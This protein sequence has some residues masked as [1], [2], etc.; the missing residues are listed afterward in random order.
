MRTYSQRQASIPASTLVRMAITKLQSHLSLYIAYVPLTQYVL[1][2]TE[3]AIGQGA[4]LSVSYLVL[5]EDK[6]IDD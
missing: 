5:V 4:F 6:A 1:S 2:F 3:Y